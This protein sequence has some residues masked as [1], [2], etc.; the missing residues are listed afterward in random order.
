MVSHPQQSTGSSQPAPPPNPPGTCKYVFI[1]IIGITPP[2]L[3]LGHKKS[4]SVI[5]FTFLS[6]SRLASHIHFSSQSRS[7]R[8]KNMFVG[9]YSLSL[10]LWWFAVGVF[11]P[12]CNIVWMDTRV[13][14]SFCL[15][16]STV[17][18]FYGVVGI[19]GWRPQHL[20]FSYFSLPSM[21]VTTRAHP[22]PR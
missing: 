10:S 1:Y 7:A 20:T 19:V 22:V 3:L 11:H 6:L 5:S 8:H 18:A 17:Q 2:Q 4:N 12:S 14:M 16:P 21:Q 9:L 13:N 15:L